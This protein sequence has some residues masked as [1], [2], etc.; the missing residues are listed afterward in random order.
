MACT[1]TVE[2]VISCIDVPAFEEDDSMSEDEFDGYLSEN[3]SEN[4]ANEYV[5][6]EQEHCDLEA[7][8]GR[9]PEYAMQ[10]GCTVDID[11]LTPIEFFGMMVDE[12]ML[13][14]IVA[15][16]ILHAEQYIAT[17]TLRPHSRVH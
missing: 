10:P 11:G 6:D 4:E 2:D 17:A 16:T 1:Y 14:H 13:D 12:D 8:A 15:Q 9:I 3:G 5:E 7:A